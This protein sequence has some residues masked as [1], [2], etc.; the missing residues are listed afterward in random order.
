M[1]NEKPSFITV[2]IATCTELEDTLK[3]YCNGISCADCN[4]IDKR[5]ACR[6]K[7][8]ML[9]LLY[10]YR[11]ATTDTTEKEQIDAFIKDNYP[12]FLVELY[13][14]IKPKL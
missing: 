6:Y 9:M 13:K 12:S 11:M 2:I 14:E 1:Q 3:N 5:K 7:T 10:G 8:N 4:F